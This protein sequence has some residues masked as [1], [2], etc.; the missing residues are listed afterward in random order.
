MKRFALIL[1]V[2]CTAGCSSAWVGLHAEK[3]VTT[4]DIRNSEHAYVLA[5]VYDC[6]VTTWLHTSVS[7]EVRNPNPDEGVILTSAM[8]WSCGVKYQL[9]IVKPGKYT[10]IHFQEST[11]SMT[12]YMT[13][14]AKKVNEQIKHTSSAVGSFV[15]DKGVITYIGTLHQQTNYSIGRYSFTVANEIDEANAYIKKNY[16]DI[17]PEIIIYRPAL[18]G[19]TNY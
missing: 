11:G 10:M 6:P 14:D 5:G 15:A 7:Y 9:N 1:L 12:L 13:V 17:D 18:R 8:G 19:I 2:I 3:A 4:A 16:P